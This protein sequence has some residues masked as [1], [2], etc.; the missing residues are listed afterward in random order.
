V[1]LLSGRG[2]VVWADDILCFA[3]QFVWE[4]P[5]LDAGICRAN[6]LR[7]Y[8]VEFHEKSE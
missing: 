2:A 8:D 5:E 7:V 3:V 4:D 1:E 6:H